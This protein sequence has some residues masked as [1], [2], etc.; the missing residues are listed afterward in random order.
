MT[1]QIYHIPG[2]NIDILTAQL[3]ELNK[4]CK[5]LG[6]PPIYLEI[7][8]EGLKY[9]PDGTCKYW[10]EVR[11]QGET[12]K[13]AGWSFGGTLQDQYDEAG[14]QLNILKMVPEVFTPEEIKL[15]RSRPKWCDHCQENR[16]RNDTYLI[17]HESGKLMQVGATCLTN[18]MGGKNPHALAKAA[19][20]LAEA[21]EAGESAAHS[22]IIGHRQVLSTL[23]YLA[24]V[25][26]AIR[27]YGWVSKGLAQKLLEEQGIRKTPTSQ[28][29]LF[30]LQ[31]KARGREVDYLPE[32]QDYEKAQE[33]LDWVR[34]LD[35]E[36]LNDY[37]FTL[38]AALAGV[39][40]D[41]RQIGYAASV[42]VA[43]RKAHPVAQE[44][45]EVSEYQ[46]TLGEKIT[47]TATVKVVHSYENAW[48]RGYINKLVDPSGNCY[49]WFYKSPLEEG[50]TH[51]FTAIVKKHQE[52]QE[53]K[54]TQIG[55]RVSVRS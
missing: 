38:K 45:Q 19:E 13:Y 35:S 17:K 25:W 2:D 42:F 7:L 23:L 53:K 18:F 39:C 11:V 16:R 52:Y 10:T 50:T 36:E 12:P 15:F 27:K 9:A 5:K 1:E 28:E 34:S 32:D 21:F 14:N 41:I 4:K 54:E 30:T 20:F 26:G 29:A 3:L 44:P 8:K 55:G 46:G 33:A 47:F 37:L 31:D 22:G 6:L 24:W 51:V 43:Y 48:G 40:L 49:T